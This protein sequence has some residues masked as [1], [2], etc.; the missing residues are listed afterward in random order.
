MKIVAVT[1]SPRGMKGATGRLLEEVIAGVSESGA[2]VEI[3]SLSQTPIGPCV[4]CDACHRVGVCPIKD[5]YEQVKDKLMDADA[6]V[7]ASPN[8]I[9]SVSGQM[10]CFFDR[11]NGLAHRTALEGKYAAVVETSGGGG[12]EEVLSYMERF[13]GSLGA[14]SVG[15]IGSPSAGPGMFP[16]QEALFEK[17]RALGRDL[18]RCVGE[19]R[20]FPEQDAWRLEFRARMQYLI[21]IMGE[22]WPY[23]REFW[24]NR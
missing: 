19:K 8:Y 9:F 1:G 5:E 10:K 4:A 23:E 16:D 7:L 20:A 18:C 11:C 15:R 14:Q 6:F 24:A 21:S 17:A 22:Y 2:E 12:D 13:V 3:V